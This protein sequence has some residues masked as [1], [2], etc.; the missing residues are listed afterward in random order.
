MPDSTLTAA[1]RTFLAELDRLGVRFMVVGMSG[2]LIQGAR[3]ATED[4]DLWFED[5]TDAPG[6]TL[7]RALE[8]PCSC[9]RERSGDPQSVGPGRCDTTAW[10]SGRWCP[11]A[12]QHRVTIRLPSDAD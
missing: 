9:E 1:E 12:R 7:I 10:R 11:S 8:Q 3:G 5:V 4:I 6:L 2:A